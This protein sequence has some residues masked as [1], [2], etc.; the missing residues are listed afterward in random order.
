[1]LVAALAVGLRLGS[2]PLLDPDEGRNAEVAREMAATNDYLIPRYNGLPYVDKPI[3][4]FAAAAALME[5]LGPTELAARLPAYAFTLATAVVVFWF[6]RRLW[7]GEAACVAVIAFLAMPLTI[8]FARTVI[9][10]SATMF[11]IVVA[12]VGFHE[13]VERRD[14]RFAILA[15]AAIGFGVLTKGPIAL[16]LPLIV[17]IPYAIWRKAGRAIWPL[18]GVIALVIIVAP[19]VWAMTRVLPD[20]LEYVLVT[21]TAQRVATKALERTGPPWYFLPYLLGGAIPWS[22]VILFN[23]REWRRRDAT[24]VFLLL[25]IAVPLVFFTLSQSKRPQYVLPLMPPIALM[26]AHSWPAIRLRVMAIA[27]VIFGS[28]LLA[29]PLVPQFSTGMKPVLVRPAKVLAYGL[30]ALSAAGGLAA[31]ILRR[32]EFSMAAL[33]LPILAIPAMAA[34]LLDALGERRSTESLVAQIRPLVGPHTEIIGVEAFAGSLAFYLQRPIVL[35]SDN[36]DELTSNYLMRRYERFAGERGPLRPL[37]W[38][39]RNLDACCQ[40]RI[41]VVRNDD[42]EHRA[43]LERRGIPLI[44]TGA[45]HVVYGPYDGQ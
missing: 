26:I 21:E 12:M 44:A 41:Y 31:A 18:W 29:A 10:D 38:Y 39:R 15:W 33:S 20:F 36:A 40:R 43:D 32:R 14:R 2:A 7:G 22:I 19:W 23:W 4:Y 35:V 37:Q 17:A 42:R 16:I 1:M 24:I 30:G 6:A 27:F 5:I 34:P 25:W 9:F 3:V 8:A 11:F 45:H 28:V 13:A